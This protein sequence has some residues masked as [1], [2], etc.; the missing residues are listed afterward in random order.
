MTPETEAKT[1]QEFKK[2]FAKKKESYVHV[3]LNEIDCG[4]A[5]R[6]ALQWILDC[7]TGPEADEIILQELGSKTPT[8]QENTE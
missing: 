3:P 8:E 6:A 7:D 4:L 2:W 1:V 5:W